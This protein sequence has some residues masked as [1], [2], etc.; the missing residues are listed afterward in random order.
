MGRLQ[1]SELGLCDLSGNGR[2]WCVD[3]LVGIRHT[4]IHRSPQSP[5]PEPPGFPVEAFG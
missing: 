5:I 1:P 3:P 2:E 4:A